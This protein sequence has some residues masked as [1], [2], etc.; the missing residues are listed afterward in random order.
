MYGHS[1]GGVAQQRGVGVPE[2]LGGLLR[3]QPPRRDRAERHRRPAARRVARQLPSLDGGVEGGRFVEGGERPGVLDRVAVPPLHQEMAP[4]LTRDRRGKGPDRYR[5]ACL[6]AGQ[7]AAAR[8][9]GN[10][11]SV[12]S[13]RSAPASIGAAK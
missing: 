9:P 4:L 12:S 13:D 2:P 11:P 10:R 5:H 3:R 7:R 8:Q 6:H 1:P